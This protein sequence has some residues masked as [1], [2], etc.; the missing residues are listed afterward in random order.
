MDFTL[1][2]QGLRQA[3]CR[4]RAR[5]ARRWA[6]GLVLVTVVT[7]GAALLTEPGV[8]AQLKGQI[9]RQAADAQSQMTYQASF[10]GAPLETAER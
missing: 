9:A 7:F 2:P 6:R 1:T 3:R 10:I 4:Q 8:R 5:T